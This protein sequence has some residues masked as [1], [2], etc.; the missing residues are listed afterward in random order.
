MAVPQCYGA[1]AFVFLM[2]DVPDG[3]AYVRYGLT[4]RPRAGMIFS[5]RRCSSVAE[6]LF[7]KQQVVRSNRIIGSSILSAGN[8]F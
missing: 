2:W 6:Q 3:F 5:P 1:R 7:R 8:G 4:S